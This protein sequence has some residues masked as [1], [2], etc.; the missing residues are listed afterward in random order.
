LSEGTPSA[1]MVPWQHQPPM[2]YF[3]MGPGGSAGHSAMFNPYHMPYW[4]S[5]YGVAM[6]GS[7]GP[8]CNAQA[9]PPPTATMAAA[10]FITAAA[11]PG[12]LAAHGPHPGSGVSQWLHA[13][14]DQPV[15]AS[16]GPWGVQRPAAGTPTSAS[17]AAMVRRENCLCWRA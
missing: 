6:P 8:E 13:G 14:V 3:A 5:P 17:P 12:A 11:P 15:A 7:S 16:M 4:T 1:A 9:P 10:P 2:A